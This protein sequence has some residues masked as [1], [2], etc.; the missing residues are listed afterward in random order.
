MDVSATAA[1]APPSTRFVPR[2][3]RGFGV[4]HWHCERRAPAATVGT[5]VTGW[6]ADTFRLAWALIYWNLRKTMFQLR[7]GRGRCPCQDPSDSGR[8]GETGCDASLGWHRRER[9]RR[10]CP[11]LKPGTDGSL[12]CSVDAANVRPFWA[13]AFGIYATTAVGLYVVSTLAVFAALRGIGYPVS[14]ASVAWPPAWQRIGEARADYFRQRARAAYAAKNFN[15]AVLSLSL[16]YELAPRDYA[17][18]LLLAQLWQ[19]GQP[20]LSNRVYARLLREHPDHWAGTAQAWFRALLARGDYAAVAQ[21]SAEA[22]QRHPQQALAWAQALVFATQRTG[23]LGALQS[24]LARGE[25]LPTSARTVLRLEQSIQT[26][27]LAEEARATLVTRIDGEDRSVAFF[28]ARRLVA[29]GFAR[30]ALDV[31][32]QLGAA[33]E[34]RDALA[35]RLDAYAR[36][37]YTR[38]RANLIAAIV[39][40]P[41]TPTMVEVLGAHLIRYP[42][43]TFYD[44][45]FA[46]LERSPLGST[47]EAYPLYLTLFCVAGSYADTGRLQSTSAAMANAIGSDSAALGAVEKFFLHKTPES[48]VEAYL[49]FL[50]PLSLEVTYALLERFAPPEPRRPRHS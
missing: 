33:P 12:R 40:G 4:R 1:V 46:K 8:G 23:D 34:E 13:R 3:R 49:P 37:G 20:V 11:L 10:V 45:L 36:L 18:G 26:A 39:R 19:T 31:L 44:E 22:V 6:L 29:L 41:L 17:S 35:V 27:P 2:R 28:R 9:F 30:E 32:D 15:E 42:S 7:G 14:Y 38:P 21:L 5:N 48:R 25:V 43:P 16:A 50:Q 47:T 24:A